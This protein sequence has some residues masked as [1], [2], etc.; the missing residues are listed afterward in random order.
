MD[1]ACNGIQWDST[2]FN[3]A[4]WD[5]N[6]Q[7]DRRLL[8][9][10]EYPADVSRGFDM[11]PSVVQLLKRQ[12]KIHSFDDCDSNNSHCNSKNS[13][14]SDCIINNNQSKN[15]F[16]TG[17]YKQAPND[18]IINMNLYSDGMLKVEHLSR[19]IDVKFN[20]MSNLI[21]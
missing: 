15:T 2:G 17:H 9:N 16:C 11:L 8:L 1:R 19:Y 12:P 4:H 10:S 18:E 6:M 5:K 3:G 13:T 14:K 21:D 7:V 20:L